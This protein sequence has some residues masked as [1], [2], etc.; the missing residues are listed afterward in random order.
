MV[1]YDSSKSIVVSIHLK[2]HVACLK[3]AFSNDGIIRNR[4][5]AVMLLWPNEGTFEN[6]FY[7][8]LM[9]AIP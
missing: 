6:F 2:V 9:I 3:D 4:R 1:E 8:N 7:V 5:D